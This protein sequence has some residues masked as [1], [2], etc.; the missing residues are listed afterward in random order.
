MRSLFKQVSHTLD[1]I[2]EILLPIHS[3]WKAFQ[4]SFRQALSSDNALLQSVFD[5]I[6]AHKGKQLRPMLTL[7]SAQICHGVTDKTI[8][9]AVALEMLHTASLVHDD[10]VDGS[11]K[12]RGNPSVNATWGNKV[13]VLTGDYMLA[14]VIEITSNLRNLQILNCVA[15]LGKA[16]SS[17]EILQLHT[18]QSMWISEEQYFRVIEQ[19]TADLFQACAEVGGLSS[20]ASM[21]QA[22]ALRT[23]GRELGI[24][25]QL[26]DDILDYSDAEDIGKPTF[27]DL[28]DGKVTLPMIIALERASRE[29]AK[30]V[31]SLVENGRINSDD[32]QTLKSFILRYDGIGYAQ[33]CMEQHR[34]KAVEALDCFR[35]DDT[36]RAMLRLLSYAVMRV[37]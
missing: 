3:D 34:L 27:S 31:R 16:L 10:V 28:K 22:T 30:M 32:E 25:F 17:G 6:I 18:G 21:K 23:Y 7:L 1:A 12:R 36:K 19:K 5:G 8:R 14:K 4:E 37:Y 15:N 13:A 11:D 24:I 33:K 2:E 29:E 35:M 9:S 26:K 20:G